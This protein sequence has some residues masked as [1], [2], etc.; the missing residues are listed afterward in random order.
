MGGMKMRYHLAIDI[1]ASNGRM[2]LG[3][4]EPDGM[5][6]E[7]IYRFPNGMCKE[8]DYLCWDVDALLGHMVTG[9]QKCGELGKKPDTLGIDTWGVDYVL[10]DEN[11]ERLSDA[12]A[13]RDERTKDMPEKLDQAIPFQDLYALTGTARQEYNTIYQMMADF[14]EHPQYRARVKGFLFMPCYLS[15]LLCGVAE[16]EYTIA[17]TSGL[18]NARTRTWDETVIKAAGLPQALFARSPVP[19]GT[20]LGPLLP[21]IRQKVGFDCTVM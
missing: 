5:Q 7:E 9:L 8:N 19:S 11:G 20:K 16:N 6:M 12:V 1:G 18:L 15:A 3:H 2:V 17:S 13:Y 14:E 10:L 21:A 4:M